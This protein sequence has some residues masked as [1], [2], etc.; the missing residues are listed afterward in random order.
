[1]KTTKQHFIKKLK[2]NFMKRRLAAVF[3]IL[4][5]LNFTTA[6]GQC[7]NGNVI[8]DVNNNDQNIGLIKSGNSYYTAITLG[9]S[10]TFAAGS[11]IVKYKQDLTLD[12]SFNFF[13][14]VDIPDPS[15]INANT[16][17]IQPDGKIV[18]AGFGYTSTSRYGALY[19]YNSDG[20]PD[21]TFG[22]NGYVSLQDVENTYGESTVIEEI[23]I[24]SNGKITVSGEIGDFARSYT[25]VF[26]GRFNS[27]GT[28]DNSIVGN[29]GVPGIN[30]YS[31]TFT[32]TYFINSRIGITYE[33]DGTSGMAVSGTGY[34]VGL[35]NDNNLYV[36]NNFVRL[37]KVDN[38]LDLVTSFGTGGILDFY[39]SGGSSLI[40]FSNLSTNSS[41][42]LLITG[43]QFAAMF[44]STGHII[45]SIL[46]SNGSPKT[47][48]G[49]TGTIDI[50]PVNYNNSTNN[51][52]SDFYT[53]STGKL[54]L[55]S[56][57]KGIFTDRIKFD[58]TRINSDGTLDTGFGVNGI[59]AYSSTPTSNTTWTG[60]FSTQVIEDNGN[61]VIS[62]TALPAGSGTDEYLVKVQSVLTIPTITMTSYL[63]GVCPNDPTAFLQ[64]FSCTFSHDFGSGGPGVI[65]Y[66]Y[67]VNGALTQTLEY[68][69]LNNGYAYSGPALHNGDKIKASLVVKVGCFSHDTVYSNEITVV[70]PPVIPTTLTQTGSSEFCVGESAQ[71]CAAAGTGYLY[72]WNGRN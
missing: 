52:P 41:G 64:N 4:L 58:L 23:N 25:N 63:N 70:K 18:I 5:A 7:V 65:S 59:L 44:T 43:Q 51:I 33:E 21:A 53:T 13:G 50:D 11:A 19:R 55:L 49:G 28:I 12:N 16:M 66:S 30:E 61:Y 48:F 22:T 46:N 15:I 68:C 72:T 36:N 67:Y 34:I 20:T 42:E 8:T 6:Q 24:E 35:K 31:T 62:G 3:A 9:N 56:F 14:R 71:L 39:P 17:K 1:M 10:S 27:N 47:S 38:N 2:I 26:F 32:N 54:V 37:L 57:Q 40:H 29:L 69:V 60:P 45:C